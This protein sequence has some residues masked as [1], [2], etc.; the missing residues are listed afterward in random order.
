[1][2]KCA[3]AAVA[4]GVTSNA[5]MASEQAEE[6]FNWADAL[7]DSG[8]MSALTFF[9]ALGGMHLV[10]LPTGPSAVAAGIAAATEFFIILAMKR[11]LMKK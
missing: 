9:T 7:I 3:A 4:A 8:I 5:P 2:T 11:G 1:M 10:T 6:K